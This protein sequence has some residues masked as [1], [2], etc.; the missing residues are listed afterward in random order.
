MN[1]KARQQRCAASN[2]HLDTVLFKALPLEHVHVAKQHPLH[3][4]LPLASKRLSDSLVDSLPWIDGEPLG[5]HR[6]GNK[7]DADHTL[8]QDRGYD[9]KGGVRCIVR[10]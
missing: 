8:I 2:G 6:D 1:N 7:D 10:K 4:L 9:A 3:L 5:L